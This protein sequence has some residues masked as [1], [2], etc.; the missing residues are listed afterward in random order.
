[1][2]QSLPIRPKNSQPKTIGDRWV[3]PPAG[4]FY[5][6]S[7][8]VTKNIDIKERT[9]AGPPRTTHTRR[10]HHNA[11]RRTNHESY[12]R[13]KVTRVL[14]T[15]KHHGKYSEPARS[16][17]QERAR[18]TN[19]HERP[20]ARDR[21]QP[22]CPRPTPTSLPTQLPPGCTNARSALGSAASPKRTRTHL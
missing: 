11:S 14:V 19:T 20:T 15:D 17:G 22:H 1:M 3:G 4:R 16:R 9:P 10:Q 2:R 21:P 7:R 8:G 13:H 12:T 18:R 6:P 5:A